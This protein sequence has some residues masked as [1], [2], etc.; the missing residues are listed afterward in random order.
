MI[1]FSPLNETLNASTE[2]P[3]YTLHGKTIKISLEK[4]YT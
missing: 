3:T 1:I 2:A 4:I